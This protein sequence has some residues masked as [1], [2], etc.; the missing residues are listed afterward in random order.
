MLEC[1]F[2]VVVVVVAVCATSSF[3][4]V[5]WDPAHALR[6]RATSLLLVMLG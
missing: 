2:V 5:G 3:T 1:F 6:S 4:S